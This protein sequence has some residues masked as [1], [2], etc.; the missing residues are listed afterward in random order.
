MKELKK[1]A[2]SAMVKVLVVVATGASVTLLLANPAAAA[3]DDSFSVSTTNACGAIDF[4]DFGPGAPGDGD[5]DDERYSKVTSLG[6]SAPA[7]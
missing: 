3:T 7:W 1:R 6:G 4:V 2:R 5:N